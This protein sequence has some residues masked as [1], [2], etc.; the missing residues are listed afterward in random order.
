MDRKP[1][2]MNRDLLQP[3]TPDILKQVRQLLLK[4]NHAALS[5]KDP[6]TGHPAIS[7]VAMA[8]LPDATPLLLTSLLAPH[9]AALAA[10]PRCALL[11]GT[12][13][14]GDP[15]AHPRIM[16]TCTA[17]T[18][19]S[20]QHEALR[21]LFLAHHPK[22]KNYIDLPDFGFWLLDI[23]HIRYNAGFGRAHAISPEQLQADNEN[24]ETQKRK[25]D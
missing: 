2:T 17:R 1:A 6:A 9:T 24:R 15:M 14:K 5:F 19:A 22:A 4:A 8:S 25:D 7:R 18:P 13:R 23:A 21:R 16:V 12:I 20:G 3:A 10:D 11:V